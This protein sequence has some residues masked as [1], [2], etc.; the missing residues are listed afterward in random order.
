[1]KLDR[2]LEDNEGRGKYAVLLLRKLSDYEAGTFGILP[3]ELVEAIKTLERY[4]LIDW[5]R[6]GTESEFFLL[7]LKDEYALPALEAYAGAIEE[8]DF[9]FATEVRE[10]ARRSGPYSQWC[11]K[12]D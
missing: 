4:E 1:M 5:G 3:K 6:Q 11:K 8:H 7:R 10:L 2:N 12:P 9:E